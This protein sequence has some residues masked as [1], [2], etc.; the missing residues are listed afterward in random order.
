MESVER[1]EMTKQEKIREGVASLVRIRLPTNMGFD[2]D[3]VAS[4]TAKD[5][6]RFLHSQ[7]IRLP[8]GSSLIEGQK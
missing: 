6:F 4:N 2:L 8:D 1:S 3:L 5:I 7:G